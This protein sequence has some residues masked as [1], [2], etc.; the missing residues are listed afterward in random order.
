MYS[1]V[2]VMISRSVVLLDVSLSMVVSVIVGSE[3]WSVVM[4]VRCSKLVMLWMGVLFGFYISYCL[5]RVC[6]V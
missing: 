1:S 6:W 4:I 5:C 2:S 3:L